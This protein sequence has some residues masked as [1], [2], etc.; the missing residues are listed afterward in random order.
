MVIISLEMDEYKLPILFRNVDGEQIGLIMNLYLPK[1]EYYNSLSANEK[2]KMY[3]LFLSANI[4]NLIMWLKHRPGETHIAKITNIIGPQSA[5]HEYQSISC[6]EMVAIV[7]QTTLMNRNLTQRPISD[8]QEIAPTTQFIIIFSADGYLQTASLDVYP[9]KF[10]I[11][12]TLDIMAQIKGV[13]MNTRP[14]YIR[15]LL[16]KNPIVEQYVKE[17]ADIMNMQL[18]NI[19]PTNLIQILHQYYDWDICARRCKFKWN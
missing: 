12:I 9:L 3:A 16:I 6:D 1:P 13:D 8:Q 7:R 2:Y 18:S 17:Y 10:N 14:I 15:N 4:G 5:L 19:F 11:H